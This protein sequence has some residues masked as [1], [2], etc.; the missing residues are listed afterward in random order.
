[1]RTLRMSLAG[2]VILGLL[3]SLS[4]VVVA[5]E[6]EPAPVTFVT[7]TVVEQFLH[8]E[9]WE[10]DP[11]QFFASTVRGYDIERDLGGGLIEQQVDWSDPRL[12]A[13]HWL[14]GN[15]HW[16]GEANE[17]PDGAIT[18]AISHLLEGP[19]GRWVGT[20]RFVEDADEQFGFYVLTGEGAY[21]GLYALLRGAPG[22]DQHGPYDLAYEGYIFEGD[23][24]PFPDAPVPVTTE[25]M[26]VFPF[27]A[28][29]AE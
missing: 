24:L 18:T 6:G 10:D 1:M 29:A 14:T 7:G 28:G 25:G 21:G 17:G 4:L 16:I 11:E 12:P 22:M 13:K 5:Q 3:A 26:Q 20:G 8:D 2:S 19:E 9:L 27:P 23:L 15:Y